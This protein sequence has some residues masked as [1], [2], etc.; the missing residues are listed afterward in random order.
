MFQSLRLALLVTMLLPVGRGVFA[1]GNELP[2]GAGRDQVQRA[3]VTCHPAN[4]ITRST[5]YTHE[6]WQNVI[7]KMMELPEG[8]AT[9]IT[10]YLAAN[11]PQSFDRRPTLVAGD[12][13]ITFQEWNVPT[14]GQRPRDPLQT[15]DGTI[16][17]AGMYGSLIGRLDPKTGEMQE[18]KLDPKAK[19]HSIIDDRD[20]NIWYTGNGNATIGMLD[21][22]TEEIKI[23]PMPDPAARDP[24]TPIFTES[25]DLWFTLQNSNMLGRLV[26]DTG[27]IKLMTLPTERARPYGIKEDSRGTIW[28][29]YRGA[30]KLARVNPDSWEI[31]EYPTPEPDAPQG[32]Y[33]RRLAIT[34]DDMI[35][36]ADSGRGYLGR[37]DP[38]TGDVKEWPS[39]SG[40][41][42]H[43]YAIEIIDDIIWYNE[44]NQRP[45]ALV[46]F[47]PKTERFQSWTIPS[48]IGIIRHMRATPEGN[49]VIHQSST[50]TVG[51]VI[52]PK[53][54]T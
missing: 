12:T 25:G 32:T 24:H 34:S 41:Q 48:G 38:E 46:R 54:D 45:D 23:Y 1:Q 28:I 44:S 29:A 5:G 20:G 13:K 7:S 43:P 21:P 16:W 30:N 53:D 36:Y 51:L 22:K 27:D 10:Q 11:F 9:E 52:I 37:L 39:P 2:E 40:P 14:L 17:W 18:Y 50:N 33:I 47:D 31:R 6:Q 15:P 42:S 3:C 26:P 19:P 8:S 4:L 49:L 35:W